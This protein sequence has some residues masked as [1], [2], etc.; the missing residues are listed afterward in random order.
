MPERGGYAEDSQW[1]IRH[2]FLLEGTSTVRV[3]G[4]LKRLV[5]GY[6]HMGIS[7]KFI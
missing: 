1:I 6:Y 5:H 4:G 3:I 2:V 7:I